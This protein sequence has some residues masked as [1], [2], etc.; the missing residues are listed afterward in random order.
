VGNQTA[1]KHVYLQVV[2][3]GTPASPNPG[4]IHLYTATNGANQKAPFFLQEA[5]ADLVGEG[6]HTVSLYGRCAPV[7]PNGGTGVV[8]VKGG[9]LVVLG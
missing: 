2:Y 3:D 7:S 5:R 8:E 4:E 1:D 9:R 6:F